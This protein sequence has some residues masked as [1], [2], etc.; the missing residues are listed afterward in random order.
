MI[1]EMYLRANTSP[2]PWVGTLFYVT[3]E[4]MTLDPE[5][6]EKDILP[7][8]WQFLG[9]DPTAQI[10][11]LRVTVKQAKPDEDLSLL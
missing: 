7:K 1:I 3:Y 6:F 8:L 9:V 5:Q 10:Q 11:R 4:Q 2:P